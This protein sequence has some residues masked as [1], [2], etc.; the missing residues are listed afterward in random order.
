[1]FDRPLRARNCDDRNLLLRCKS[2]D[3]KKITVK[4]MPRAISADL[5]DIIRYGTRSASCAQIAFFFVLPSTLHHGMRTTSPRKVR[6][7]IFTFRMIVTLWH[8]ALP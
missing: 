8:L 5:T 3:T 4:N 7:R 2:Y 6:K 1:M